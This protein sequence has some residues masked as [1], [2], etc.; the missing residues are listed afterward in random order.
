MSNQ[1]IFGKPPY[2][3]P[4]SSRRASHHFTQRRS[5]ASP[6]ASASRMGEGNLC[7]GEGSLCN[8]PGRGVPAQERSNQ[9]QCSTGKR[10]S[11]RTSMLRSPPAA[12]RESAIALAVAVSTGTRAQATTCNLSDGSL[13]RSSSSTALSTSTC[14]SGEGCASPSTSPSAEQLLRLVKTTASRSDSG[15]S[16]CNAAPPTSTSR[17]KSSPRALAAA[18]CTSSKSACLCS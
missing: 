12:L 4:G 14:F 10:W 18:D 2:F 5:R 16:I 7:I 1:T 6:L 11:A 17:S 9:R 3:V 13:R 8:G 15:V